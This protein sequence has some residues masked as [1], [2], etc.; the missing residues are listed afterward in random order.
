LI[1]PSVFSNVYLSVS[2]HCSFLIAPSE[3]SNGYLSVSLDCPFWIA[4]SVENTEYAIKH[5]QSRETGNI[6]YIRR[7]KRKQKHNT[8]IRHYYSQANTNNVNTPSEFSNGYLSVSLDCPFW[9]APSVFSNV[10]LSVSLDCSFLIAPSVFS[11]Y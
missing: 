4:P 8:S 1:A 6:E 5:G 2:L 3:F 7:R 9:I 10:Y 11:Q